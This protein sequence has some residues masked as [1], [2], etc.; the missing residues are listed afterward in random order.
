MNLAKAQ[1]IAEL[2]TNA[3]YIDDADEL[4]ADRVNEQADEEVREFAT[5]LDFLINEVNSFLGEYDQ[6]EVE[7]SMLEIANEAIES[8]ESED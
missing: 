4:F 6:L 8:A 7:Q 5:N 3:G 2:I 1:V